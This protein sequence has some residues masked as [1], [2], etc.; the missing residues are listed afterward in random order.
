MSLV[1]YKDLLI[2]KLEGYGI[3]ECHFILKEVNEEHKNFKD[4]LGAY[5]KFS[6][7]SGKPKFYLNINCH[8]R[9][10]NDMYDGIDFNLDVT[11]ETLNNAI[12]DTLLHEYGHSIEEFF[13]KKKLTDKSF[14]NA[15]KILLNEFENMEDFAESFAKHVNKTDYLSEKKIKNIDLIKNTYVSF[16]FKK[17]TV[18][19]LKKRISTKIKSCSAF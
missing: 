9:C 16:V 11:K 13:N 5:L 1:F 10:L 17:E 12:I 15:K 2:D 19:E 3:P 7:I 4:V 14:L 6:G 18:E 8:K